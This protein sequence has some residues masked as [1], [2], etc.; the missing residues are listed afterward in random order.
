MSKYPDKPKQ[1]HADY[2]LAVIKS[3]LEKAECTK[4]RHR[5]PNNIDAIGY[6]VTFVHNQCRE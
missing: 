2:R 6:R 1:K 3:M 5:Q 4:I